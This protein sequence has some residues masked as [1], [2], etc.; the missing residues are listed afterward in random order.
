[1]KIAPSKKNK[2]ET[3]I[4]FLDFHGITSSSKCS[5]DARAD[6]I[7]VFSPKQHY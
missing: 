4:A 2:L 1:L 6:L 7:G 3:T 5:R